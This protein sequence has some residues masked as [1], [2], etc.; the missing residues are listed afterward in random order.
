MDRLHNSS[1]KPPSESARQK[2]PIVYDTTDAI[3]YMREVRDTYLDQREKYD[4][5]IVLMRAYKDKR[6]DDLGVIAGLKK[7]FVGN[8]NLLLGFNKFL[9]QGYEITVDD[10]EEGNP[11]EKIR[12]S[13][14]A[15]GFV[16][17]IKKRFESNNHVCNSFLHHLDAY[18]HGRMSFDEV[19]REVAS[20]FKDHP[21][22]LSEFTNIF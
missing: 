1:S 2:R 3:N 12:E 4:E 7:L 11:N 18:K 6:V 13:E 20:L 16:E 22:L 8:R 19:Y 9:P 15:L 17:K 10:E 14:L 5:F 21:D